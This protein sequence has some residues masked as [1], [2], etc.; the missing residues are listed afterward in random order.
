[1]LSLK[2]K[3]SNESPQSVTIAVQDIRIM[4]GTFNNHSFMH[5]Y[6][7]NNRVADAT[8]SLGHGY[9]YTRI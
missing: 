5:C 9:V 3:V 1:M 6:R 4:I 8:A 7:Q 2:L